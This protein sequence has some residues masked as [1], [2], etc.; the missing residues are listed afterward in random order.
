[1]YK[2]G[3]EKNG[4]IWTVL[5]LRVRNDQQ[6]PGFP[7]SRNLKKRGRSSA[8]VHD[9]RQYSKI[10]HAVIGK[11]GRET[12]KKRAIWAPG[13]TIRYVKCCSVES[14]RKPEKEEKNMFFSLNF[15]LFFSLKGIS[16]LFLKIL[17]VRFSR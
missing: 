7:I 10:G 3:R 6:V 4:F 11:T 14:R 2:R 5:T 13:V 17:N 1:M 12:Q 9:G 16:R 8:A 15:I